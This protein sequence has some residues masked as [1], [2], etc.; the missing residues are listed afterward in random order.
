MPASISSGY[1]HSMEQQ[2]FYDSLFE[3]MWL[4]TVDE[5]FMKTQIMGYVLQYN[6]QNF[7][8]DFLNSGILNISYHVRQ[9]EYPKRFTEICNV[10]LR[11]DLHDVTDVLSADVAGGTPPTTTAIEKKPCCIFL[12]KWHKKVYPEDP[13]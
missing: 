10:F 1:L 3:G 2:C 5:L 6:I 8:C 11:K 4:Q 9:K 7:T 12:G 13:S